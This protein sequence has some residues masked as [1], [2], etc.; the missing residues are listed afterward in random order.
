MVINMNVPNKKK[1]KSNLKNGRPLTNSNSPD[2]FPKDRT[3]NPSDSAEV[4]CLELNQSIST[5]GFVK[6]EKE[7]LGQ[8]GFEL[9][10]DP[11]IAANLL[12]V[13]P[14]TLAVWRSTNRYSLPYVKFG[15]KIKYRLSDIKTFI[16]KHIVKPNLG[17]TSIESKSLN[18]LSLSKQKIIEK[19]V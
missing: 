3:L 2:R 13:T 6:L 9:L 8:A 12:D 14:G 7:L 10:W 4:E 5:L 17:F 18:D 15:G 16:E 19:E 1:N 11:E